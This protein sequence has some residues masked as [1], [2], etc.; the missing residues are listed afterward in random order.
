MVVTLPC[1]VGDRVKVLCDS[2]GDT[3]NYKTTEHGKYLIGKIVS[4]TINEQ[5]TTI[6]IKAE[7][8]VKWRRCFK[9]Y[10]ISAIGITVFLEETETTNFK[11]SNKK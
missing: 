8:N 5:R 10:P 7:H 2:W 11:R 1:K 3:Y 4:I 6:K 9:K